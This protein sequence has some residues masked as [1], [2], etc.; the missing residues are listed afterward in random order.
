[1][2]DHISKPIDP[3]ELFNAL[4]SWIKPRDGIGEIIESEQK[5]DIEKSAP[6]INLNDLLVIEN[7]DVEL[8]LQRVLGNRTLYLNILRKYIGNQDTAVEEIRTALSAGDHSTAERL[9]HTIKGMS[10]NIGATLLQNTAAEL[11]NMIRSGEI[12]NIDVKLTIFSEMLNTMI[13]KIKNGLPSEES[14]IAKTVDVS[15]APEVIKQLKELLAADSSKSGALIDDN[16]D[17]LHFIL[18][19]KVFSKIDRAVKQ[20]DLDEALEFLEERITELE[21]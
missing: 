9:A 5:T 1:M 16:L 15:K 7:L 8:G 4:L 12:N 20:F 18:G 21:I 6:E 19:A 11:E 17:L 13:T 2:Q 3:E 14:H 10:G